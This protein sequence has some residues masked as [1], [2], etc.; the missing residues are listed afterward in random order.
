MKP[1]FSSLV[2]GFPFLHNTS[3][4]MLTFNDNYLLLLGHLLGASFFSKSFTCN[5]AFNLHNMVAFSL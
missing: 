3:S 2:S 5:M 1:Q 4:N